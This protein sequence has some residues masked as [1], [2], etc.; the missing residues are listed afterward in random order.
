MHLWIGRLIV[1]KQTMLHEIVQLQRKGGSNPYNSRAFAL[2]KE[3][4]EPV[5]KIDQT[6]ITRNR[7]N[8][9]IR[10]K[11]MAIKLNEIEFFSSSEHSFL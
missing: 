10:A 11:S 2:N 5:C 3:S 9:Q 7:G 8:S 6:R 4:V 1:L